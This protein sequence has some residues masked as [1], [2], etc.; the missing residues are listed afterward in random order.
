MLIG[1]VVGTLVTWQASW[2]VARAGVMDL[3]AAKRLAITAL[4]RVPLSTVL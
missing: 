4:D 1:D 2:R 3:L